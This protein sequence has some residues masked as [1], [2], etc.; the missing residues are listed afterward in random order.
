MWLDKRQTWAL[1]EQCGGPAL[2]DL[3]RFDTHTCYLGERGAAHPWGHGCG[4]CPA[5][6]L[7]ARGYQ[8]YA[9]QYAAARASI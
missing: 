2:V 8:Q 6:A 1:A 7:R 5:C 9:A 3:I 4:T